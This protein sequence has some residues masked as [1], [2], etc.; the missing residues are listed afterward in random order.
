L[1]LKLA[2]RDPELADRVEGEVA[3]LAA[4]PAAPPA[5]APAGGA[6]A[7]RTRRTPI[8]Q[9]AIRRQVR[10]VLRPPRGYDYDFGYASGIVAEMDDV[11]GQA[12]RF[13]EAGD[14]ASALR[15]LEAV[16]EEYIRGWTDFDDSDGELGAFF[17]D[18]GLAWAEALLTA[19]LG[20][21]ERETWADKLTEWQ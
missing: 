14:G 19:D 7:A 4:A 2:E 20:A 3:L 13:T 21:A 9:A 16:S 18:L 8:D 10:A 17:S 11:L 5:E 15:I 6:E 1:V 12:R